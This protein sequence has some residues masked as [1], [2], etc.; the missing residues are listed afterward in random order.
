MK[1]SINDEVRE[2]LPRGWGEVKKRFYFMSDKDKKA[3]I[4]ILFL[5]FFFFCS[6]YQ[7][8]N[9]DILFGGENVDIK[10]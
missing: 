7:Y 1:I 3:S 2:I 6:H 5:I 4:I 9:L 10:Q 8:K